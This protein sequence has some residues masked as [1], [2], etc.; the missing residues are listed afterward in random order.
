MNDCGRTETAKQ[1]KCTSPNYSCMTNFCTAPLA[2]PEKQKKASSPVDF[3]SQH[4]VGLN[5][6]RSAST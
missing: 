4:S 2:Y 6:F 3:G 1:K 5:L